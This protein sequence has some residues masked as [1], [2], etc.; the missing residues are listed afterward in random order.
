[1]IDIMSEQ[2]RVFLNLKKY[3]IRTI[4]SFIVSGFVLYFLSTLIDVRK[5]VS[6][7]Q[8][9]NLAYLLLAFV[10]FYLSIPVRTYRWKLLL[11][12]VKFKGCFKH[13][14]E[15]WFLAYFV[16]CIVPAKLG[17]VY[18]GYLIKKNFGVPTSRVL[19]T[20]VVERT[21]DILFLMIMLSLSGFIVFGPVI[22]DNI[23][24][25]IVFGYILAIG[26]FLSI[27]LFKAGRKNLI[28]V[29]PSRL[30]GLISEFECGIS[31]SIGSCRI[32]ICILTFLGWL[33]EISRLYIVTI[34]LGIHVPISLVVFVG[35]LASLLSSIPLTPAGLGVVELAV[36]SILMFFGY[37][38]NISVS[39]AVL[40]RLIS[41][42]SIF[43]LSY[44]IYI[45]SEFI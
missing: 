40:D 13:I 45:R 23:L 33:I 17:D 22:P 34:A 37:D 29:M 2:N 30:K 3:R 15:I 18:R 10:V 1:M 28:S 9:T 19:G 11:R 8:N 41:Y 42:V 27:F 6:I 35:L 20:I 31:N 5:T 12:N 24:H 14:T 16:N 38:Q 43:V 26:L 32:H 7:L 4:I 39:V 25:G 44:V 21:A 36:A